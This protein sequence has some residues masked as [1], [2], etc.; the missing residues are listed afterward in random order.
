MTILEMNDAK[1]D[2]SVRILRIITVGDIRTRMACT[3]I[4]KIQYLTLL[5]FKIQ[6]YTYYDGSYTLI[7]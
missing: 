5:S 1:D 6:Y 4:L 3:M 7:M 2:I